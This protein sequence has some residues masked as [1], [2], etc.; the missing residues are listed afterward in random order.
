MRKYLVIV[1]VLVVVA[2]SATGGDRA[3]SDLGVDAG[4]FMME[5][6]RA[7]SDAGASVADG[8]SHADGAASAQE[9][10]TFSVRCDESYEQR[11]KNDGVVTTI[12][13]Q[14]FASVEV[15]TVGITGVDVIACG[16]RDE[17]F[18]PN[19]CEEPFC[20]G[21]S[22]PVPEQ[23]TAGL[24]AQIGN[25]TIRVDCGATISNVDPAGS[26]GVSGIHYADV[27]I[28]VRRD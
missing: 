13:R 19:V 26:G 11:V 17:G 23:C 28:T 12:Y 25:D 6:G 3:L 10:E 14:W 5:A 2:C 22:P 16:R 4:E 8:S 7:L 9:S 18:V 21:K 27:T 20:T 24:V 1:S 15:S